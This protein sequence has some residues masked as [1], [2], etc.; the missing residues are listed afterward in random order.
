MRFKRRSDLLEMQTKYPGALAAFFLHQ[1]RGK[2]GQPNFARVN[3][4]PLTDPGTWVLQQNEIKDIR[5]VKELQFLSKL[6]VDLGHNRLPQA[7][8][9]VVQRM[10]EIRMAKLKDGSWDKAAVMSLVPGG[11]AGN[12]QIP[13]GAMVL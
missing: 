5:D 8:D 10:R 3:D 4:V 11:L 13:D 2:I 12:T 9:F 1:V 6:L 7:A